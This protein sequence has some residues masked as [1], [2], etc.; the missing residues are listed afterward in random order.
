MGGIGPL[1]GLL[2][3]FY[4]AAGKAM[5]DKRPLERYANESKRLVGVL[6]GRLKDRQ[7]IMG[8]EY[9]IA[10]VA[11]FPWLRT[12]RDYYEA[13]ELIGFA[14]FPAA[15][16]WLDRCIERPA[17]QKGLTIPPRE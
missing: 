10:D 12:L 8:D 4:K 14:D 11:I 16:A 15:S 2:G 1:F 9:T 5:E 6:E 3:F 17:S 7:W 13:D